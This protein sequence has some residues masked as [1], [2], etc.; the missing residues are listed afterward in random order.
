MEKTSKKNRIFFLHNLVHNVARDAHRI[1]TKPFWISH[2]D[3]VAFIHYSECMRSIRQ[4]LRG[5][6]HTW[7]TSVLIRELRKTKPDFQ[8]AIL[9]E[10]AERKD[11]SAKTIFLEYLH[12]TEPGVRRSA[13]RGLGLLQSPEGIE[14]QL[15]RER[16]T[17]VLLTLAASWV[18]AG[19]NPSIA[20]HHLRRHGERTIAGLEGE[21]APG[22]LVGLGAQELIRQL[23]WLDADLDTARHALETNNHTTDLALAIQSVAGWGLA[24]DFELLM[25]KT[26]TSGRRAEHAA[27]AAL[28]LHGDPRS[29]RSLSDF[30]FEMSVDPGRGFAHRRKAAFALGQ[31]GLQSAGPSLLRALRMERID[32]EGRPGAGLGI[33]FPVRTTIVWALGE[34]QEKRAIPKLIEL[35][36]EDS[37]SALGGLYLSAMDALIKIGPESE[38]AL[39][40]YAQQNAHLPGALCAVEVLSKVGAHNSIERLAQIQGPL[41]IRASKVLD[42]TMTSNN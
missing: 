34:T 7:K 41:G 31:I 39:F 38:K 21:R 11:G 12:S 15:A 13:A 36:S 42:E 37:G 1:A 23:G 17:S 29:I 5:P 24:S 6:I 10:L 32:H 8:C 27:I 2:N 22:A 14:E 19:Q 30:L 16:C 18:Q 20:Q 3:F 40:R 33:Q 9:R 35:L 26:K 28:G 25:R 4:R